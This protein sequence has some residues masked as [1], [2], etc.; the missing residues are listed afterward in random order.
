MRSQFFVPVSPSDFLSLWVGLGSH[1][2]TTLYW[3]TVTSTR[4]FLCLRLLFGSGIFTGTVIT[5]GLITRPILS[6]SRAFSSTRIWHIPF[7]TGTTR[8]DIEQ[9]QKNDFTK[10]TKSFSGTTTSGKFKY[11][12]SW[13]LTRVVAEDQARTNNIVARVGNDGK[14]PSCRRSPRAF[15]FNDPTSVDHDCQQRV[16]NFDMFRWPSPWTSFKNNRHQK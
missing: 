4:D 14:Y 10:S 15:F 5:A 13:T 11:T 12:F 2:S 1:S 3:R 6:R 16:L 8:G 9:D 7:T